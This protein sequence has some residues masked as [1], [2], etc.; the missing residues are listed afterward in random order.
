MSDLHRLESSCRPRPA[1]V[2]LAIPVRPGEQPRPGIQPAG[3]LRYLNPACQGDEWFPYLQETV[4]ARPLSP[5]SGHVYPH[6]P[7]AVRVNLPFRPHTHHAASGLQ[8]RPWSATLSGH[9][10][11]QASFAGYNSAGQN[12][13]KAGCS[14][15]TLPVQGHDSQHSP[16]E[17]GVTPEPPRQGPRRA[18]RNLGSF[19]PNTCPR[20]EQVFRA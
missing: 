4:Q 1:H 3:G 18:A 2:P 20:A 9:H 14:G 6:F 10:A 15:P 13:K 12:P 8:P 17:V 11:P 5:I 16:D 19:F 7:D